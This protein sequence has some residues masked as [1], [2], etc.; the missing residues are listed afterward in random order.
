MMDIKELVTQVKPFAQG[1]FSDALRDC[2]AEA[3]RMLAGKVTFQY[4][5]DF[6]ELFLPVQ[7]NNQNEILVLLT[8]HAV[9]CAWRM[10]NGWYAT[11]GA[12]ARARAII[13]RA[14]M[15]LLSRIR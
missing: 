7:P 5:R 4:F 13:R 14:E 10:E 3:E 11:A 8:V 2:F 1:V 6:I 12:K 9:D 15:E